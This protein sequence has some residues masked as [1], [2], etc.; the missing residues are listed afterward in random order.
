MLERSRSYLR[1]H[2]W[3][4]IQGISAVYC[5]V[6][7]TL[8]RYHPLSAF[9]SQPVAQQVA[10]GGRIIDHYIM[11][12]WLWIGIVV[13]CLSLVI[14]SVIKMARKKMKPTAC[15][16]VSESDPLIYP[17]FTDARRTAMTD[18][19]ELQAYF[20]LVNRGGSDARNVVLEPIEIY[21][22]VVQFTRHR[23]AAPLLPKREAYF[24]PDVVTK[25]NKSVNGWDRDLF[26]LLYQDYL[27]LGDSTIC[28][29][30]K[31]VVATYQDSTRNLFE[32]TCELVLNPSAH[33]DVRQGHWG[34]SPVIFTR[35]HKFRKVAAC[36]G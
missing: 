17:E 34:P 23:I 31:I 33:L 4:I 9:T 36:F 8:D 24:Y 10:S 3:G 20:T 30:T 26:T 13:C 12:F 32:V 15:T 5:A 22:R 19:K 7:A 21:E 14:P 2:H 27:A 16:S 35:N 6:F 11:P 29:I 18:Q 28:E 1:V 25:D